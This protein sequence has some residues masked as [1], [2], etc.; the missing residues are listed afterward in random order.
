[1]E[2]IYKIKHAYS[3][4][5]PHDEILKLYESFEDKDIEI[6][7]NRNTLIHLAANYAD[8]LTVK[9]L[10]DSGVKANITNDYGY[11]PLRSLCNLR[12]VMRDKWVVTDDDVYKTAT[13]LLDA[14]VSV[15]KK[16]E[17]GNTCVIVAA[18]R[19]MYPMIKALVDKGVKIDFTN[20]SGM[21]PLHAACE[22]IRHELSSLKYDEENL[23]K[24][25]EIAD[26]PSGSQYLDKVNKESLVHAE[27][28][29][30]ETKATIDS[31][32]NIVKALVESGMDVDIKDNTGSTAL[33]YA[34]KCD[35]KK[36]AAYLKGGSEDTNEDELIAGGMNLHQAASKNDVEAIE[37]LI[38][39]GA[40]IH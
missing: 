24:R 9:Y 23:V 30:A 32:F 6:E 38:R 35:A 13:L 31:Y 16:D 33:D 1:M 15:L 39:L 2:E 12:D 37:A 3:N 40:D 22:Y 28:K 8:H 26:K 14:R 18:E 36:I 20:K 27:K 7:S 25:K 17:S 21:T 34:I 4:N 5:L 19:G 29:L 11:T 10:L